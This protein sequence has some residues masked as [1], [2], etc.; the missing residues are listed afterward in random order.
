MTQVRKFQA[1]VLISLL[2]YVA[3]VLMPLIVGSLPSEYEAVYA[4]HAYGGVKWLGDSRFF[5]FMGA[6]KFIASVGLVLLF[7]WGRWAQL[8]AVV[9]NLFVAF[10]GGVLVG[11]PVENVMGY[12]LTMSEGAILALAFFSPIAKMM[13]RDK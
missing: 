11:F 5:L 13:R 3:W 2:L 1:L 4:W 10:F 12:L 7:S 8:V 6:V 9:I